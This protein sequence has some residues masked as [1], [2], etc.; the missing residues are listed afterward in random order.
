LWRFLAITQ[1]RD[2]PVEHPLHRLVGT[3]ATCMFRCAKRLVD[4][5]P[6]NRLRDRRADRSP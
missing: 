3:R 6:D 2:P 1:H 4:A 5:L